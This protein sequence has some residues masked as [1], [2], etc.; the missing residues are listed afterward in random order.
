MKRKGINKKKVQPMNTILKP[1]IRVAHCNALT[2]E[3]YQPSGIPL[4]HCLKAS[5]RAYSAQQV[6]HAPVAEN[7]QM[8]IFIPYTFKDPQRVFVMKAPSQSQCWHLT[9]FQLCDFPPTPL[10]P[11]TTQQAACAFLGGHRAEA[12]SPNPGLVEMLYLHTNCA[13]VSPWLVEIS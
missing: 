8:L 11:Q 1:A 2:G 5:S 3:V 4:R 9:L 13:S 10:V 6:T 12:H 7:Q